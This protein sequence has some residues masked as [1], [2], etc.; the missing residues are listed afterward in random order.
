MANIQVGS[1]LKYQRGRTITIALVSKV[2]GNCL[3]STHA[4]TS[5]NG[6]KTWAKTRKIYPK[7]EGELRSHVKL[8]EVDDFDVVLDQGIIPRKQLKDIS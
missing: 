4:M 8:I 2:V 1:L 6:G 3:Y 5:R 7:Y